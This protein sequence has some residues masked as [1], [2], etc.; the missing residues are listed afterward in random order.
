MANFSVPSAGSVDFTTDAA[1]WSEPATSAVSIRGFP[2]GD[3]IAVSLGG[4]REVTR[5]VTCIFPGR[6][7]YV[8]FALLRGKQGSLFIDGWDTGA[9]GAVLKES[10][11]DPPHTDGKVMARAQFVLT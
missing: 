2:G 9:V 5:T 6:G 1:S 8:A 7:Q 11:P 3:N 10:N 4:Q